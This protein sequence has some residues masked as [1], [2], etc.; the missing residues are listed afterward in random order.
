MTERWRPTRTTLISGI[1]VVA[2]LLLTGISWWF[3]LLTA[4]GTLG[5]GF[6]REI[7]WLDDKDEFQRRTDHRAG[8]HAFLAMLFL[9]FVL[10]AYFR[11]AERALEHTERLATLFVALGWFVWFLSSVMAYWGRQRASVW[12]L[13]VFGSVVLIFAILSNLGEEWTGWT[14]LLL[15]PLIAAPFFVLAWV[16]G[17]WPRVGGVL[18]LAALAWL[19]FLIGVPQ[20][21]RPTQMTEGV[22]EVFLFGP[23][24]CSGVALLSTKPSEEDGENDQE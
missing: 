1:L 20:L 5:P 3:L 21:D 15:H 18:L 23:L 24:L 11:S 9:G 13:R 19:V 2:G 14:A 22:V 16:A 4:V 10:V 12:I 8:Y 6:L 17:R 7:G